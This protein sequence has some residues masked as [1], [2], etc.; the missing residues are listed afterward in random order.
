MTDYRICLNS[1]TKNSLFVFTPSPEEGPNI[2]AI[3]EMQADSAEEA[4][5]T[6]K[7]SNA[8]DIVLQDLDQQFIKQNDFLERKEHAVLKGRFVSSKLLHTVMAELEI[9]MWKVQTI[10]NFVGI[11]PS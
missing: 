6:F 2:F 7:Y 8:W 3:A 1:K 10:K 4:L 11:L 9:N 5:Y